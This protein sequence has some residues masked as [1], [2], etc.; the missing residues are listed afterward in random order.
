MKGARRGAIIDPLALTP[1]DLQLPD[2]ELGIKFLAKCVAA[3]AWNRGIS[4]ADISAEFTGW[5]IARLSN[6]EAN[7]ARLSAAEKVL[8]KAAAGEYATAGRLLRE[9]VNDDSKNLATVI[10]LALEI[11]KRQKWPKAGGAKTAKIRKQENRP[12][13]E[14]IRADAERL[15]SDGLNPRDVSSTLAKRYSLSASQIRKIRNK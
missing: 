4:E 5:V 14:A 13:N 12:R 10:Q 3:E 11:E 1:E 9:H 15:L 8:H 2:E 7:H 6:I